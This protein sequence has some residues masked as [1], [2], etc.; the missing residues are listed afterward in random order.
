MVCVAALLALGCSPSAEVIVEVHTDLEPG[1]EF[2]RALARAAAV[3][4]S[5]EARASGYLS[6]GVRLPPIVV[7]TGPVE[8]TAA[9]ERAGTVVVSRGLTLRAEGAIV[10]PVWLVRACIDLDCP[11]GG[12]PETFTECDGGRCVEPECVP[13][14]ESCAPAACVLDA[15]CPAPIAA[16]AVARCDRENC[17]L[18]PRAGACTATDYCD[19]SAGCLPRTGGAP[20]GGVGDAGPCT[21]AETACRNGADDDCDG[22]RDCADPDCAGVACDDANACTHTD[23]CGAATCSGT[24]ISC[25]TDACAARSC[26]GTATC[27]V[28]PAGDGTPCTADANPCTDDTCTGG[29]CVGVAR[30]DNSPYDGDEFHR[31]CGGSPV[32][33]GTDGNCAWCGDDCAG[34]G[35]GVVPGVGYT[36]NCP[37][38]DMFCR[39][40]VR[41]TCWDG[42]DGLGWM[43]QCQDAGDCRAGQTCCMYV[44]GGF[45]HICR[46]GPC[47]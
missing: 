2:D 17:V 28:A 9:L 13:T 14:D 40:A 44:T 19:P 45:R 12:V 6:A 35:C 22:M 23:V 25:T 43:C 38:S 10:V 46:F 42:G 31:C 21:S 26:N 37:V 47:F 24:A 3:T 15:D 41:G 1:V 34:Q 11:S 29:R 30:P 18:A 7:A 36:C 5:D 16:C 4:T 32:A 27:T 8:L 39:D 20:D 33:L